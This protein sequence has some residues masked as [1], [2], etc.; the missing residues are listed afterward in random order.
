MGKTTT[1][2]LPDLH[3]TYNSAQGDTMAGIKA[4]RTVGQTSDSE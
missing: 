3:M 4:N 2:K 1:K